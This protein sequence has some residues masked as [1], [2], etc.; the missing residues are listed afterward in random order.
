MKTQKVLTYC[1][2]LLVVILSGCA[3]YTRNEQATRLDDESGYRFDA[4]TRA[5]NNSNSLF[6]CLAFSGGGTRAAALA[7]GVMQELRTTAVTVEG[8]KKTLLDEVDCISSVSG[9]GRS[10]VPSA[11]LLKDRS[12]PP[13]TVFSMNVFSRTSPKNFSTETSRVRWRRNF[14]IRLIFGG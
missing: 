12:L 10:Q 7:Y 13:I 11:T 9:G 6:V 5:S 3:H 14:L 4:L 8:Q 2:L 1:T